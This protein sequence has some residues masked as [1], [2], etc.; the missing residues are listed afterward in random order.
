MHALLLVCIVAALAVAR[1]I[2]LHD[3][4]D[5]WCSIMK[6]HRRCANPRLSE[7]DRYECIGR[8]LY[9]RPPRGERDPRVLHSCHGV[10]LGN[11]IFG[12]GSA[13][14]LA[15][16]TGMRLEYQVREEVLGRV[17]LWWRRSGLC[18][19]N[20]STIRCANQHI[21]MSH[22]PAGLCCPFNV[23]EFPRARIRA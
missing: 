11:S 15:I 4:S 2:N 17:H 10:G 19:E 22:T 1:A 8:A 13:A 21:R 12:L 5:T 18:I 9:R 3:V 14:G 6:R 23:H 16:L 20:A 7:F